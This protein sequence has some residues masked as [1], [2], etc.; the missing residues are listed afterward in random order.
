MIIVSVELYCELELARKG[1]EPERKAGEVTKAQRVILG[2]QFSGSLIESF[3]RL[4][5]PLEDCRYR[6]Y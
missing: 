4:P 6:F 1:T 2:A 5:R 3:A